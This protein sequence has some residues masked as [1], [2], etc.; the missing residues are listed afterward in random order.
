VSRHDYETRLEGRGRIGSQVPPRLA[1]QLQCP[2]TK[3][4][5]EV[6]A[7]QAVEQMEHLYVPDKVTN[8][9]VINGK[10]LRTLSLL[11]TNPTYGFSKRL[12]V[13]KNPK[14]LVSAAG[15]AGA[16]LCEDGPS[17]DDGQAF[18]RTRR[19]SAPG[20]ARAARAAASRLSQPGA[21]HRKLCVDGGLLVR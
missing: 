8:K 11:S 4:A 3:Q 16:K 20:T 2:F 7:A 18:W 6:Y 10:K 17:A 13:A 12:V 15:A 19:G 14:T 9:L 1:Y 5:A 21:R